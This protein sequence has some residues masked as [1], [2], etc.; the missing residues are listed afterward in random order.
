[1]ASATIIVTH[2]NIEA[3]EAKLAR[4][5]QALGKLPASSPRRAAIQDRMTV[6]RTE[7]AAL[8]ASLHYY[9]PTDQ[10][11]ADVAAQ[12]RQVRGLTVLFK[13]TGGPQKMQVGR[14]LRKAAK[15]LNEM[16]AAAQLQ[17]VGTGVNAPLPTKKP[18]LTLVP[19]EPVSGEHARENPVGVGSST[20]ASAALA[21]EEEGHPPPSATPEELAAVEAAAADQPHPEFAP[22]E[23]SLTDVPDYA[24]KALAQLDEHVDELA[25]YT[26]EEG[27]VWYKNPIVLAGAGIAAYLIL[28]R[29]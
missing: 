8:R 6:V 7:V 21:A 1:V 14:Q 19:S 16:M 28:R 5:R 17:Q 22:S 15:E 10:L 9:K 23:F 27:Q 29:R 13:K 20:A 12:R 24:E 25:D 26:N 3:R 2:R 4:L 18:D 11:T